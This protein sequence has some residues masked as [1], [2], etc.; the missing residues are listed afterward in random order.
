MLQPPAATAVS[1]HVVLISQRPPRCMAAG[2]FYRHAGDM[3]KYSVV[4]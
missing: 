1:K 3:F 2:E 4:R